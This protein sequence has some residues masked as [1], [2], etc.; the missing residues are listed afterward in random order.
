MADIFNLSQLS[1]RLRGDRKVVFTHGAFDLFHAGH[2]SFLSNTKKLGGKLIV[3]IDDDSSVIKYKG[4]PIFKLN[5]R[6][7]IISKLY[8]VDYVLI[9]KNPNPV[10]T[11][12][13][14][15]YQVYSA[16]QPDLITYGRKFSAEERL[17]LKCRRLGIKSQFVTD[18]YQGKLSTSNYK[19][20]LLEQMDSSP[21]SA[22]DK[23]HG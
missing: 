8:F 4:R 22:R 14:Y 6:L 7:R 17:E 19:K 20:I 9:V 12:D 11:F 23:F 1:N 5:E 16:L 15:Y 3:G 13:D 2:L 21:T 18:H 10:E